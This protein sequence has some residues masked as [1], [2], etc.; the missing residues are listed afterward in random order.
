MTDLKAVARGAL[1][2]LARLQ[3]PDIPETAVLLTEELDIVLA[4]LERVQQEER[5]RCAAMVIA[6]A[7]NDPQSPVERAM[8]TIFNNIATKLRFLGKQEPPHA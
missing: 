4:A 1:L 2:D 5:K 6:E 3:E 7:L 8:A